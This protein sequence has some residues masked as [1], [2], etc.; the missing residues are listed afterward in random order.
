MNDDLQLTDRMVGTIA[1]LAIGD[2]LGAP[3]QSLSAKQII[4]RFGRVIDY[5][6]AGRL[7][8]AYTG[9]VQQALCILDVLL[10]HSKFTPEALAAKF[11]E[12]SQA[13]P[14][15][16][17][18]FGVFRG[19][20]QDFREAVKALSQGVPWENSG[21]ISADNSAAARIAPLAVFH[22]NSHV[23]E[24][25]EDVAKSAWMTHRDPRAAAGALAI[26]YSIIHVLHA[27]KD[28]EPHTYLTELQSFVEEG[29]KYLKRR[30]WSHDLRL[31]ESVLHDV[32]GAIAL[33]KKLLGH[34]TSSALKEIGHYSGTR[35]N[36]PTGPTSSFILASGTAAIY[37]FATHSHSFEEAVVE[38]IN[39]GGDAGTVGSM[40]GAMAGALYGESGI[41]HR[42]RDGLRN[43]DQIRLRALALAQGREMPAEMV[44][45]V[46]LE[47]PLALEEQARAGKTNG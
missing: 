19:T 30:F 29:E 34:S 39:Q 26:A 21:T 13:L 20:G 3:A 47:K 8:N 5:V 1:G 32:S 27:G 25:R 37:F 22:C 15:K 43:Y 23:A 28:F 45:L 24:L 17:P 40:V 2:A 9:N 10:E 33:V 46:E 35:A 44:P 11:V 36:K 38:A 4:D 16:P 31:P 18:T 41:P 42:W 7:P 6:D 14:Q 12:L